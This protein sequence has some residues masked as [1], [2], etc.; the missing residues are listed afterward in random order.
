M[1]GPVRHNVVLRDPS[2]TFVLMV[3]PPWVMC[4]SISN[5]PG[6]RPPVQA[7][8]VLS[9]MTQIGAPFTI[10]LLEAHLL[11]SLFSLSLC[12]I[13]L[14]VP[15]VGLAEAAS[16]FLS[17]ANVELGSANGIIRRLVSRY[18]LAIDHTI[19][20]NAIFTIMNISAGVNVFI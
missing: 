9:D 20:T 8:S 5:L 17:M 6:L 15:G 19:P 11:K 7:L 14:S 16:L 10:I 12:R 3:Y 4:F 18:L 2:L 13:M 1:L